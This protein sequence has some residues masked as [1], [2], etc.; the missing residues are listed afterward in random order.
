MSSKHTLSEESEARIRNGEISKQKR[1]AFF[2]LVDRIETELLPH[3][4]I[5]NNRFTAWFSKGE[6]DREDVRSF[7]VQ[8]SVFSNLFLEAQLKKTI[9][10]PNLEA[11]HASKEILLNELGVVFRAQKKVSAVTADEDE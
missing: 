3:E 7:L 11:M 1:G 2:A 4:V 9:N 5:T 10:A 8:F 6:F